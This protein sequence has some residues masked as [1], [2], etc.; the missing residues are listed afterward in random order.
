MA[1]T[2]PGQTPPPE[3]ATEAGGTHPTGMHSC[4]GLR[5][6]LCVRGVRKKTKMA[7]K[8]AISIKKICRTSK[9]TDDVLCVIS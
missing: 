2:L 1:D 6:N 5:T 8:E 4:L 9:M 3:M 7:A